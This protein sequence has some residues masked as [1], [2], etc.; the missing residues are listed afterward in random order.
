MINM[1]EINKSQNK[2]RNIGNNKINDTKINVIKVVYLK[3][4]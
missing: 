2:I 4:I 3:K 1:N